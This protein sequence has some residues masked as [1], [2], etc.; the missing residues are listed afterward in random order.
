MIQKQ[1]TK[2]IAIAANIKFYALIF[3]TDVLNAELPGLSNI[4]GKTVSADY[5]SLE[6]SF[7]K[8]NQQMI[9]DTPPDQYVYFSNLSF[10]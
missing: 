10:S 8:W 6:I 4:D 7:L 1:I 2:I 3:T 9:G 5:Q